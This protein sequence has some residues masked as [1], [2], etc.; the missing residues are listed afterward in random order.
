MGGWREIIE[1]GALD[2]ARLDDL[3]ATVDHVGV[4]IGSYPGTLEIEDR[5]DG[6]HWAVDPPQSRADVRE[7]VERGDLRAGSWRMVVGRDEWRGDVRHVHE[8]AELRDVAVVTTP[9]Y[10]SAAVE[11]RSNTDPATGQED[12]MA[13]QA[14][15]TETTPPR[16]EKL[17]AVLQEA[18]TESEPLPVGSGLNVEDRAAITERPRLGLADEFRSRGFPGEIASIPYDE[19]RTLTA[20]TTN[21]V[22]VPRVEGV[23]YGADERYAYSAFPQVAVGA[24][25]TAVQIMRQSARSLATAANVVRTLAAVTAGAT[26]PTP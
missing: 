6:L 5:S 17:E 11:L 1:P 18:R 22:N 26:S 10:E 7:A 13:D 19:Y 24:D 8:I 15:N 21:T 3:V 20:P 2:A 9:A 25:V 23:P 16:D 4:P 12:D 14:E